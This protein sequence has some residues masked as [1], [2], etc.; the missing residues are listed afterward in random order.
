[1]GTESV[2]A[3]HARVIHGAGD[4]RRRD[5]GR[6]ECAL[7]QEVLEATE[8]GVRVAQ[9]NLCRVEGREPHAPHKE[10]GQNL[11]GWSTH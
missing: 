2:V 4:L 6:L 7:L 3:G 10:R 1:M 8:S 5:Q 11:A 9:Q